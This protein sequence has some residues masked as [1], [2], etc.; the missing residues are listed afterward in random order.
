M[1]STPDSPRRTAV[2]AALVFALMLGLTWLT[3]AYTREA[4]V[5]SAIS[6]A[7]GALL[8]IL[9]TAPRRRWPGLLAAG[10]LGNLASSLLLGDPPSLLAREVLYNLA[11]VLIAAWPL[12]HDRHSLEPLAPGR[13]FWRFALFAIVLAPLSVG[14]LVAGDAH[15]L[16]GEDFSR[17]LNTWVS[18]QALGFATLTPAI[19]AFR[20]DALSVLRRRGSTLPL[21][22]GLVAVACVSVLVFGQTSYPLLFLLYP[23]LLLVALQGGFAGTTL[24]VLLVVALAVAFTEGGRGPFMLLQVTGPVERY[25]MMQLFFAS[26][27]LSMFPIV[28]TIAGRQRDLRAV[29]EIKNRLRVLAEY[30]SDII[31]LTDQASRRLYVSPAVREVLGWTEEEFLQQSYLHGVHPDDV[32]RVRGLLSEG[33]DWHRLTLVYRCQRAD[34]QEIWLETQTSKFRE[35]AHEGRV[36]T[37]RDITRRRHA[38]LA[39]E[40]A[41]HE[42]ASLVW[43][44]GLTGLA[45]RR[46]FD[47]ALASEWSRALRGRYPLAVLLMDVDHFKLFNDRY[48]HQAGDHCLITVAQTLGSGVTRSSDLAARYGGEEFAVILPATGVDDAARLAERIRQTITLLLLDHRGS[49]YGVVTVSMGVAGAVPHEGGSVHDIVRAADEALYISKREGR[50]CTTVLEVKWS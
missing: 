43:T 31:L 8:G 42:L 24:S 2:E 33:A 19:Y 26:L 39:L 25:R 17:A 21:L 29:E 49:P 46:R 1:N 47:E 5:V 28:A 13:T 9:L 45:N 36:V 41:N 35:G 7:N 27:L 3:K 40:R 44:D 37:M 50:N 38:E 48:G 10:L 34:G 23:P 16:A 4:S 11:E 14:L 18:A 20:L 22:L 6:L 12:R 15:Y 32:E 30:S